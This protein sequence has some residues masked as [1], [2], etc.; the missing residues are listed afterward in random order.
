M[1]YI[2]VERPS[3]QPTHRALHG[4]TRAVINNMV[5][6]VSKGFERVLEINGV[7]YRAEMDGK[8]MIVKCRFFSSCGGGTT[9]GNQLCC[10]H[11]SS[12]DQDLRL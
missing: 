7:G 10:G 2:I 1:D 4:T 5:V 3:D 8:N 11:E 12:P 6:G 9:G